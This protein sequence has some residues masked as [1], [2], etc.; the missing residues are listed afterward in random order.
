V[1][2]EIAALPAGQA[3]Q[4]L[5]AKP[6]R[7]RG[8]NSS[9]RSNAIRRPPKRRRPS[10]GR[11]PP[12]ST[13]QAQRLLGLLL[14]ELPPSRAARLAHEISGAPRES[15]YALALALRGQDEAPAIGAPRRSAARGSDAP[16]SAARRTSPAPRSGARSARQQR[17]HRPQIGGLA[18]LLGCR[19][20]V[21]ALGVRPRQHLDQGALA[22][23]QL[24]A[25]GNGRPRHGRGP[26]PGGQCVVPLGKRADL[27]STA[28]GRAAP[29]RPARQPEPPARAGWWHGRRQRARAFAAVRV[30]TPLRCARTGVA[31][32]AE[33]C[34]AVAGPAEPLAAPLRE[35]TPGFQDD[36][37]GFRGGEAE[38]AGEGGGGGGG[39]MTRFDVEPFGRR[40][41]DGARRLRSPGSAGCGTGRHCTGAG[42]AGAAGAGVALGVGRS[43]ASLDQ[44]SPH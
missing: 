37:D 16:L 11:Q 20:R 9:W 44:S 24:D 4:W 35:P 8:E 26:R 36:G 33:A 40:G 42:A 6:E 17:R 32:V 31:T 18:Q 3:V 38:V 10:R 12:N 23:A 43:R 22:R 30:R 39:A 25:L 29:R 7:R 14:T 1:F 28:P 34:S 41:L 21:G 13:P 15:L 2:E 5:A 19:Q 27:Q